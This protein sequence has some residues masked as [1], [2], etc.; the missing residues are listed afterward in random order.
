MEDT[1]EHVVGWEAGG[2]DGGRDE[3]GDGLLGSRAT[4]VS[5]ER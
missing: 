3:D 5:W 2:G 1:S 4:E